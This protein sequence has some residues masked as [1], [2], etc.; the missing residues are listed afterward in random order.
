M[1][2]A[3]MDQPR[4]SWL[5]QPGT[6]SSI[7]PDPVTPYATLPPPSSGAVPKRCV[8]ASTSPVKQQP[9]RPHTPLPAQ[10]REMHRWWA[11][12]SYRPEA[13]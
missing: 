8:C 6:T 4:S 3:G 12:L 7:G 5:S 13:R 1:R 10:Q 2:S 9:P 11:L